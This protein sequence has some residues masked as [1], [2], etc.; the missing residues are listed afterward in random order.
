[1]CWVLRF[2]PF[3]SHCPKAVLAMVRVLCLLWLKDGDGNQV[4]KLKELSRHFGMARGDVASSLII[5][6]LQLPQLCYWEVSCS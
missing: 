4:L 3:Q 5:R 1:M 6:T 2:L